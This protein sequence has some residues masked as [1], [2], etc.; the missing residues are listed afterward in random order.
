MKKHSVG[1][2][3][4]I[5][6][7][8]V[9]MY[10]PIAVVVVYSFN[11]NTARIPIDF[12]GWTTDWYV[13]LFAGRSGFGDALLLSVRVALWS[14]VI[15]SIIGT[16]GAVGM[17]NRAGGR[18]SRLD[19]AMESLMSLPIMIPEII[20]GL[21]FMV[22]FNAMG[23]RGNDLRLVLAHVTFCIPYVFLNVKSRLV[24]MDPALFDAARDLGAS[25]ARVVRDITLPLC[26]PAI[27]SG[28]FLALAMSLDDF[29]ISFFV[30]GAGEGTLPIK[31]Y[32]SVKVGVSPQVNALCTL[33]M[34][35]VF[36]AVAFSRYLSSVRAARQRRLERQARA[37]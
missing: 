2:L 36:I 15:S 31:I 32:S 14:V 4:F 18:P 11:A 21:A 23:I 33:I 19:T 26:R 12:T 9:I 16:L 22:V 1:S 24:G 25:P 7:V 13:K 3:L 30:Y 28:A 29:V 37:A 35:V 10:L 20:L 17:V 27:L 8:L 6:L 5:G 34:G